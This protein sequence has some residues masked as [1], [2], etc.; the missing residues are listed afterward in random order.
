MNATNI[1][2]PT[3]RVL[4]E[5]RGPALILSL[6]NPARRNAISVDMW[7][8]IPV[9]LEQAAADPGIRLV[10][11]RGAGEQAFAAGADI[12]QFEDMRAAKAAVLEYE[13]LAEDALMAL[14]RHG[15][16]TLAYIRGFCIGGGLNVAMSCD[17][18]LAGEDA[19]FS[20]PAARLGLGYRYSA[21]KNLVDIVGPAVAKDLFLTA[22]RVSAAEAQAVGLVTRV[23]AVDALPAL[24]DS[25][26]EMIGENAPLTM[27]AGKWVIEE[28]L[29]SSPDLDAD[30]CQDLIL[31]CF[32][33][34]D[35]IEGRRAFMEKRRPVFR[36][37]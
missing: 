12:S 31:E 19:V 20:V 32:N 2:S 23:A 17:L 18:R 10:V 7:A 1:A 3:E 37:A 14:H 16:P 11:V 22:R 25:Y 36:G 30:R 6:N 8:A 33:S 9:L 29:T 35:Y 4:A 28:L 13:T 21:M 15:K 27:R 26:I 5:R 24:L 34:A